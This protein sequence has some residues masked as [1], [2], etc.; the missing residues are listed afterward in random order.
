MTNFIRDPN[1]QIV[2]MIDAKII[3]GKKG[4]FRKTPLSSS[5]IEPTN[6]KRSSVSIST[7]NKITN[8]NG[9]FEDSYISLSRH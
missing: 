6:S 4:N 2:M 7:H 3:L 9:T 8:I 1:I 5:V